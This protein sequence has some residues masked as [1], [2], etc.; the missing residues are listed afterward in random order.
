MIANSGTEIKSS[1]KN[2]YKQGLLSTKYFKQGEKIES[3]NESRDHK[4]KDRQKLIR[5]E[6]RYLKNKFIYT[7]VGSVLNI[8]CSYSFFFL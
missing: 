6:Y 1:M 4:E 8:K 3:E 2:D 5:S 7:I